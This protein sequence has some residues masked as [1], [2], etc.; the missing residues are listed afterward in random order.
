MKCFRLVAVWVAFQRGG[1]SRRPAFEEQWPE[2]R[3]TGE[4]HDPEAPATFPSHRVDAIDAAQDERNGEGDTD[5]GVHR[6]NAHQPDGNLLA[7]FHPG[8]VPGNPVYPGLSLVESR[9]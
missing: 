9:R 3:R 7:H 5:C 6:E 8:P 2:R 4:D 1:L